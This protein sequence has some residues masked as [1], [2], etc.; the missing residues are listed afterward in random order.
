MPS[1]P[2]PL[3][4]LPSISTPSPSSRLLLPTKRLLRDILGESTAKLCVRKNFGAAHFIELFCFVD[5]SSKLMAVPKNLI[6]F[7]VIGRR[8]QVLFA[9]L[10]LAILLLSHSWCVLSL[11]LFMAHS[12]LAQHTHTQWFSTG[13]FLIA[14]CRLVTHVWAWHALALTPPRAHTQMRI[15]FI[16]LALFLSLQ[17]WFALHSLRLRSCP[18]FSMRN[19]VISLNP[20]QLFLLLAHTS[21]FLCQRPLP[22]D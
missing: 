15:V 22:I 11:R 1:G 3:G 21:S 2:A 8:S 6:S 10:S 12:I 9:G 7:F 20:L 4:P 16:Y 18:F 14:V 19:F 5:G 17:N 13:N